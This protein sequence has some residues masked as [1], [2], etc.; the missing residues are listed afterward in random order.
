M[1]REREESAY[2]V[3]MRVRIRGC[4]FRSIAG[5]LSL[6]CYEQR[7]LRVS[8]G[9]LSKNER[10]DSGLRLSSTKHSTTGRMWS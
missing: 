4:G 8:R 1:E 3:G 9:R 6:G 10:Q 2:R 7:A 5:D